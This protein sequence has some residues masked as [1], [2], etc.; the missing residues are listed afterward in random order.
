MKLE[1]SQSPIR[2]GDYVT[3]RSGAQKTHYGNLTPQAF[4]FAPKGPNIPAQGN[5]LGDMC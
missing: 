5:A 2:I 4:V 1:I 3:F